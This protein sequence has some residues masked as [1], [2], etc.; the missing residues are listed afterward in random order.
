MNSKEFLEQAI[1]LSHEIR[2][3]LAELQRL[4]DLKF[5]NGA[6]RY[7]ND[8]VT[9]SAPQSAK[10][11]DTVIRFVDLQNEIRA[12]VAGLLDRHREIRDVIAQVPDPE[13]RA[14]LRMKY[15][16]LKSL[17]EIALELYCS[18]TTVFRR[19]EEGYLEVAKLTGLSAPP[20]QRMPA[21]DRHKASKHLIRSY[22][23][24]ERNEWNE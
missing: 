4:D 6:I 21:R 1:T 14:V 8:R 11:E 3:Q 17:N 9:G 22:F 13:A 23:R 15:L 18:K 5:G 20:I 24:N 10:F 7:D 19:M 16:A 2:A 12:E